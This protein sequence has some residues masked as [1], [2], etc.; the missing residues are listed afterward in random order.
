[1]T[2]GR[3][4][5]WG[6]FKLFEIENPKGKEPMFVLERWIIGDENEKHFVIPQESLLELESEKPYDFRYCK[7]SIVEAKQIE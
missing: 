3:W 1:M 7:P 6:M 2:D 4:V 5:N